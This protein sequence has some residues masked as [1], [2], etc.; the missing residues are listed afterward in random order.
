VFTVV[1][2]H[3]EDDIENIHKL[4]KEHGATRAC[5]CPSNRFNN[6]Q[7]FKF[8]DGDNLEILEKSNKITKYYE[9]DLL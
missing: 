3:N 1:F 2:K 9:T 4:A 7:T 8:Y 6:K 5:V